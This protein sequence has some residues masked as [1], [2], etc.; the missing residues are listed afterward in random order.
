MFADPNRGNITLAACCDEYLDSSNKRATTLARDRS[1]TDRH[2]LPAL[3]RRPLNAISKRDVQQVVNRMKR[4]LAPA[5]VRTNYGVLRAILSAAVTADRIGR[6]PCRR[7]SLPTHERPQTP[8]PTA[9]H[10]P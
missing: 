7:V 3:G 5:T 8:L 1:V 6:S 10:L 9:D 2:L 4:N